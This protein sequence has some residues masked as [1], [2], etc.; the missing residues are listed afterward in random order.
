[1]DAADLEQGLRAMLREMEPYLPDLVLIGGWVPY[2][3][4]HYGPFGEWSGQDTLTRELD[5]LVG[6]PLPDEGRLPLATLLTEARF[7]AR[8]PAVWMR[9]IEAGERIEFLTAHH[10]VAR[11]SGI[12][13]PLTGQPGLSAIP[14]PG[15]EVL[16][17]D[18]Q[19]LQ[20]P[21]QGEWPSVEVRVP[22]LGAYVINK[23]ATFMQ[24]GSRHDDDGHPKIAKDLLYL[25]DLV[26]APAGVVDE[27]ES[28]VEHIAGSSRGRAEMVRT[29]ANHLGLILAD[30]S[31][32]LLRAVSRMVDERDPSSSQHAAQARTAGYLTDLHEILDEVSRRH[33]G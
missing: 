31:H 10:G 7:L 2:L 13:I 30:P 6:Q 23:A 4:R 16:L 14:L 5:V 27:I 12:P 17:E 21:R 3:Y 15:L 1:M 19:V 33:T 8:T 26:A 18:T 22:T 20:L 32:A 11:G 25:R 9:D 24:R 29:G 28:G